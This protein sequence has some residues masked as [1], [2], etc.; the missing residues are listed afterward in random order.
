[1]EEVI[2]EIPQVK[3]VAVTAVAGSPFA[4]VIAGKETAN[5]EGGHRVLQTPAASAPCAA[6][7]DL[8]G[9]FPA[10]IYRKGFA[11]RISKKI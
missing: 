10:H 1:M 6:L 8:H 9:R 7:C 5:A 4:F 3:E 11:Q 2:Y